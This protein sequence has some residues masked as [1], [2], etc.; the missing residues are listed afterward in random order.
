MITRAAIERWPEEHVEQLKR[1]WALG[2]SCRQIGEVLGCTRNAVIGKAHRLGLESRAAP[3]PP[4]KK[5]PRPRV[6]NRVRKP[7]KP[8]PTAPEVT[9]MQLQQI[10]EVPE[11]LVSFDDLKHRECKFPHGD[12]P[13]TFCGRP[14]WVGSVYCAHHHHVC[15]TPRE[16]RVQTRPLYRGAA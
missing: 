12:G 5:S 14:Q 13:Y 7:W 8:K 4:P 2:K 11:R 10:T 6:R 1:L 15:Y 3:P 16:M 9:D